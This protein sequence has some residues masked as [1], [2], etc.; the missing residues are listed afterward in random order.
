M[1][2]Y[3]FLLPSIPTSLT[4]P[5]LVRLRRVDFLGFVLWSA[6]LCCFVTATAFG[7]GFFAWQSGSTISL[8][9]VAGVLWI[10]FCAQ[11]KFNILTTEDD[12]FFPVRL[13]R[14]LDMWILFA[15]MAAGASV[16]FLTICKCSVL[17]ADVSSKTHLTYSNRFHSVVLPV[18]QRLFGTSG[19][20]SD[21]AVPVYHSRDPH[22]EQRGDGKD[23]SV[24]ALVRRRQRHRRSG[25][26][27]YVHYWD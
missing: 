10:C 14:S 24:H 2:I 9:V 13:L 25:S 23:R 15:Q 17:R 6:A 3:I 1:P 22:N 21:C 4:S 18:H 20:R 19:R 7:G 5:F 26:R 8:Y 12:R 11:Q 27:A 16:F